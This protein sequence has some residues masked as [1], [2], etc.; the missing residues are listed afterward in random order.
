MFSDSSALAQLT[1]PRH[2][3]V[4]DT[5]GVA[6]IHCSEITPAEEAFTVTKQQSVGRGHSE[7]TADKHS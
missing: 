4:T 1:T 6:T 7:L 2:C 3:A 5:L